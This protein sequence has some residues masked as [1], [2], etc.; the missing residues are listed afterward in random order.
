MADLLQETLLT[1]RKDV[2]HDSLFTPID[3]IG[4]KEQFTF[5]I[6]CN[7]ET[8]PDLEKEYK[9]PL[10]DLKF[11]SETGTSRDNMD[12]VGI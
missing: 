1:D 4:L 8:E 6:E 12:E 5:S 2:H 10:P 11:C 9:S 7:K 3:P